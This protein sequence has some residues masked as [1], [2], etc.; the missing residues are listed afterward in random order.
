MRINLLVAIDTH[1]DKEDRAKTVQEIR[2]EL[3]ENM[4]EAIDFQFSGRLFDVALLD[5]TDDGYEVSK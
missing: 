1:I 3:L 4:K 2:D 5:E